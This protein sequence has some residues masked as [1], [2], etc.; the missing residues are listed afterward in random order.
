MGG[1]VCSMIGGT[2]DT[3]ICASVPP[4]GTD[5]FPPN[6]LRRAIA[7]SAIGN[8]TEWFDYG[9]YAYGLTYISA[10]LFPGTTGQA[11][12][13]A[14]AT[15]AISFLV[16]PLGGLFWG[17]LGDRFGRKSVLALTILLMSG[18]TLAVRSELQSLMRISYAVFCLKN[19]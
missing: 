15:F 4:G 16:R 13:F 19:K 2:G 14:L 3:A 18:A 6:V 12:L 17:P 9:I 1:G 10:A 8:A 11:T 7:A 5:T